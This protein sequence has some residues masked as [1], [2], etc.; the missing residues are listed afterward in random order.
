MT[1]L[2]WARRAICAVAVVSV[3]ALGVWAPDIVFLSY[4]SGLAVGLVAGIARTA[5]LLHERQER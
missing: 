5:E 2:K 4:V 3:A 1:R